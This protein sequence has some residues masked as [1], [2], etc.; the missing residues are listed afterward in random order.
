M[1]R[2]VH[3]VPHTHWD[4]EWYRTFEAFRARLVDTVDRVLDLLETGVRSLA[5]AESLLAGSCRL[6]ELE[7]DA[8]QP[9]LPSFPATA[10]A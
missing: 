7:A 3:V 10:L 1:A 9:F 4:R 2:T 8:T 5:E 6:A